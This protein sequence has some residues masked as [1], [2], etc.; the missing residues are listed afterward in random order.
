[1]NRVHYWLVAGALLALAVVYGFVAYREHISANSGFYEVLV[2]VVCFVLT[3]L[4]DLFWR[5]GPTTRSAS[6]RRRRRVLHSR[7]VLDRRVEVLTSVKRPFWRFMVFTLNGA[8]AAAAAY[9]VIASIAIV[10][11]RVHVE[12][13]YGASATI[14]SVHAVASFVIACLLVYAAICRR[15]YLAKQ[16]KLTRLQRVLSELSPVMALLMRQRESNYG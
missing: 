4:W 13:F 11:F 7:S 6:Q 2:S 5:Y 14:A 15:Q 9:V 16:Y 12:R 1:M 10:Y 8:V 3:I